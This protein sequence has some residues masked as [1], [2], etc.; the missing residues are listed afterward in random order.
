M[1]TLDLQNQ[2]EKEIPMTQQLGFRVHSLSVDKAVCF[3]PLQPNL[4][5]K[6]TLFG[7]SQY[8][9]C[10]LACYSL[11]LY[12]VRSLEEVTNNI[13]VSRGEIFYKKPA[14][15]DVVIEALWPSENE[16]ERFLKSLEKKGKSRVGLLA[17][18][19]SD[20]GLLLSEFHGDFVVILDEKNRN[21]E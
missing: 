3:L 2:L 7:G 4:N 16:R 17:R 9:G 20:T 18:V 6:G 11:F 13:V 14:Q 19:L 5:H 21:K 12:N 10:A 8:A 15:G 1:L